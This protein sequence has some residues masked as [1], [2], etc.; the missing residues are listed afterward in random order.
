MSRI[1]SMYAA[2]SPATVAGA[3]A[4]FHSGRPRKNLDLRE[5]G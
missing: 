2:P 5:R 1:R 4:C 3:S